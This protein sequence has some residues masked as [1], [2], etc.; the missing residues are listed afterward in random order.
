MD[1]S[2]GYRLLV[3][4][5]IIG[6]NGFFA[7]AETALVSVRASRLRQMAE[8]GVVGASAA[9][10][11][12]ANPERL[13]SVVQVGVTLT[14]LALGWV[15]EDTLYTLFQ[16]WLEP[17]MTPVLRGVFRVAILVVSFA[18]MTFM[19]VV[20]GE[21]VP[22]NLAIDKADRLAI[23]VAPALL[24]FYKV[25]EPFVWAIERASTSLSRLIGVKGEAHAGSHSH[26]ELKFI[27]S[28][29]QS[30]GLLSDFESKSIERLLELRDY[31]VRE[32]MVPRNKLTMIPV[33]ADIDDLLKMF[34]ETRYSRL[35]VF[36]GEPDNVLGAVHV[37]DVLDIWTLRRNATALRR[38]V[39]PFNLRKIL[40]QVPLIP[41]TKP[42]DQVMDQFRASH[43]HLAFVVDEYGSL[44]GLL[45]LEDVIEQ[46]FGEIGDEFDGQP[47]QRA[48]EAQQVEVEGTISLV[49]LESHYGIEIPAEEEFETLAGF[50]LYK[51]E[52]IPRVDDVVQ[53]GE[54]TFRVLEMDRNR[55]ARV[56]IEKLETQPQ[57]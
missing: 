49:D 43:T 15:G 45:T 8:Q 31:V 33:D 16:G 13:L 29:S 34:S 55:V 57:E 1:L 3:M 28:A 27:V 46:V 56:Q 39:P 25:A 21:V 32:V 38:S 4:M 7:S 36:E 5:L 17:W 9:L 54:R 52:R 37:K 42:M 22:K 23:I 30:A 53:H 47:I 50:L 24:V 40:R 6:I 2:S 26:E 44:A 12:L 35:P 51:L 48:L 10:S 18:L 19:H 11:L 41:E 14:S 20:I